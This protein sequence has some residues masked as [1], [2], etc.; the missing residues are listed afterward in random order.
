MVLTREV[1]QTHLRPDVLGKRAKRWLE[2]GL[3]PY[4]VEVVCDHDTGNDGYQTLFEQASGLL[5]K[6]ADKADRDKGIQ[7]TQARF[8]LDPDDGKPRIWFCEN[9]L[10]HDPDPVLVDSGLPTCM[11]EE[12]VGYVWDEEQLKDEPIDHNDHHCDEMRYVVRWVNSNLVGV[13]PEYE[14]PEIEPLVPVRYG[15]PRDWRLP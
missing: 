4:P 5:L 7:D 2:E 12:L 13:D 9:T 11:V 8:D 15:T 10:D 14:P 6:H 3:E 1:Y